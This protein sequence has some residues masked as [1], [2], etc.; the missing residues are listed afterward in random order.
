MKRKIILIVTALLLGLAFALYSCND[1]D[2]G[3]DNNNTEP[4]TCNDG[5]KNQGEAGVDCGGPCLLCDSMSAT[6]DGNQWVADQQSVNGLYLNPDII[7]QGSN[8]A[9]SSNLQLRYEGMWNTQGTKEFKEASYKIQTHEYVLTDPSHSTVD[10]TQFT[11]T[12][13]PS[14]QDSTMTGSFEL[15]LVDTLSSP[16]DTIQVT[17]GSFTNVYYN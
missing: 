8:D 7:I 14:Q 3:D 13:P 6:I 16:M 17:N 4:A 11:V 1:D 9:T 10:F 5:I 15:T 2:N 12:S